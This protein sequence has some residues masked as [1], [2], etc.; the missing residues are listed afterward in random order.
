MVTRL[1]SFLE[2][3]ETSYEIFH[4]KLWYVSHWWKLARRWN[5]C[6]SL[7][8]ASHRHAQNYSFLVQVTGICIPAGNSEILFTAVINL[9][10]NWS[11][12]D[13]SDLLGFRNKSAFAGN[14][15]AGLTQTVGWLSC[16][17]MTLGS[18]WTEKSNNLPLVLASTVLLVLGPART[19][20]IFLF[21]QRPFMPQ[22]LYCKL[23]TE[24]ALHL[25][26]NEFT[27]LYL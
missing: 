2:T 22:P 11:D 19:H 10:K 26:M 12:T 7:R 18:I 14:L 8:K 15:N 4:S 13:V 5:C 17:V 6:S 24:E 20:S 27:P 1:E 9:C 21:T 23:V 16:T 3:P 25:F